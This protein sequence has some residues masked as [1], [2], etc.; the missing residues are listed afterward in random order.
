MKGERDESVRMGM[1]GSIGGGTGGA[2]EAEAP[3]TFEK[4][5]YKIDF[6]LQGANEN[7][8]SAPPGIK[9]LIEPPH[10]EKRSAATGWEGEKVLS[11]DS[12]GCECRS[13]KCGG[14]GRIG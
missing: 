8:G 10:S 3:P 2:G 13:V 11:D 9:N 12:V 1:D 5:H 4:F 7:V 14:N 6:L